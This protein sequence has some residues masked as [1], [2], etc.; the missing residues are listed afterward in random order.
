MWIILKNVGS[1]VLLFNKKKFA[2]TIFSLDDTL[3]I[4]TPTKEV[5]KM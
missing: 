5:F 4:Y 2:L 1:C 3:G